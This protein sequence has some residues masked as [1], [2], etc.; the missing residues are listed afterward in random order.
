MK[1]SQINQLGSYEEL[2]LVDLP[3]PRPGPGEVLI[4][5]ESAGVNFA[6]VMRRRGDDYPVPTP[7]PFVPGGEV[8][9]TVAALGDGVE[10]PEV[11]TPVFAVVGHDGSGGYAEL[12]LAQASGVIPIP[13]GLDSDQAAGIIVAGLAATLI[14]TQTAALA[15]GESVL[16]PAAAGGAGSYAVQI[17]KQL[18]AGTVIAAASTEAKRQIA[19]DLG[20]DHAVDYTQ[21]GWD[22]VVRDLTGGNGVDV[23]LEMIGGRR[24]PETLLAL[25]PFG[26]LVVFGAVSGT[27]GQLDEAAIKPFLYDPATNQSLLNFNLGTW[28]A[29]KPEVAGAALGQLVGWVASGAITVPATT[30]LPLE[31]AGEAH[32]LLETGATTGKLIL[33]P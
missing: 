16:V 20:A 33:K 25:G 17:A 24:L 3:D 11:G 4:K 2:H 18:G 23:A 31:Q 5:V 9:G 14:L 7:M 22:A 15:E 8:A 13:P 30:T 10:G 28:F 32:R 26:R 6:D 29:L 19:L 27:P 1:A 12:A 21:P